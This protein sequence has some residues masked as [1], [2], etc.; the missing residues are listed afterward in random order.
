MFPPEYALYL[1]IVICTNG[2]HANAPNFGPFLPSATALNFR[3]SGSH[4]YSIF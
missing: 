1:V 3:K 2:A 4:M